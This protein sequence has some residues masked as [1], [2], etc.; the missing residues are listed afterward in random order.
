MP[1]INYNNVLLKDIGRYPSAYKDL[2][3][4]YKKK[5]YCQL[6]EDGIIERIF[7]VIGS[8]NKYYVEFGGW[9]GVYLSNTANLRINHG[10]TGLLLE[11]NRERVLST[12]NRDQLN[13][14][15]EW[16]TKDNINQLF[17]KYNVP[18]KFDFLSVDID[19]DDYY[20]WKALTYNPRVV[21]IETNPGISNE[22]PVT[23]LEG[24]SNI[25]SPNPETGNYFGA[26]LH[27]FLDLATEKGYTFLTIDEYN[28]FFVLNEEFH[29]FG[30]E[31]KTKEDILKTAFVPCK[32]WSSRNVYSI[33]P[34]EWVDL[35]QTPNEE[36]YA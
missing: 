11:G 32:V 28:A 1:L 26:N 4:P 8:T 7:D 23:I 25:Y 5:V 34:Y 16:I 14:R 35:T 20:V 22:I 29:K 21:V 24:R 19:G 18:K 30:I 17:D 36:Q 27:A 9:D 12:Y 15:H 13:L 6:G 3:T 10:W 2:F 31:K 33:P